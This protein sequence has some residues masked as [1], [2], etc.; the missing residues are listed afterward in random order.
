MWF[1]GATSA[2]P[3]VLFH[4]KKQSSSTQARTEVAAMFGGDD[5]TIK[6]LRVFKSFKTQFSKFVVS[7]SKKLSKETFGIN[8]EL[9]MNT[10]VNQ[11][12][13]TTGRHQLTL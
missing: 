8:W 13:V 7:S 10:K 9:N 4:R 3:Y 1:R 5:Q 12:P 6:A 11:D 2:D